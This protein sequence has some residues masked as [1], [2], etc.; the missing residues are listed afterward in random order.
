MKT[1]IRNF[2]SVLMRF[3]MGDRIER[4]RSCGCFRRFYR[5]FDTD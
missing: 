4:S 5:D 1:I 3:K 2:L